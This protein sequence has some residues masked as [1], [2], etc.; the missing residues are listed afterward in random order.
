MRLWG[1]HHF[2]IR[3]LCPCNDRWKL[4]TMIVSFMGRA[5]EAP[6]AAKEE[7]GTSHAERP[8]HLP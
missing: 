2:R 7:A 6:E 4:V 5:L 8:G 1:E 3:F